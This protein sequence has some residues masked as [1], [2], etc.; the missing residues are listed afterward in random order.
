MFREDFDELFNEIFGNP[1]LFNFKP[2]FNKKTI[3]SKDGFITYTIITNDSIGDSES[4]DIE[5]LKSELNV[6]VENQEF[7]KAVDLRDKIKRLEINSEKLK[8]LQTELNTAIGE[9]NFERCIE[10]RDEMNKLK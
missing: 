8:E 5:N 2:T 6:A 7:E 3:K 9:Q 1:N 4:D 10:L